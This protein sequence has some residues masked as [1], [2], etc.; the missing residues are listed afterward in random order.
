MAAAAYFF[1]KSVA[2]AQQYLFTT[3]PDDLG[4]DEA[5]VWWP[6]PI[7]A[8]GGLV[9][10]L[11]IRYLPGTGGHDPAEGF[12]ASG[13][14]PPIELPGIIIAAFAT[15]ACG[16]V[17]GPEAPLIA[18]GSGMGVLAVHLIRRNAP[19]QASVVIAAAGSFAA[20]ST[21]FGSPLTG[22]FLLME[23]SGLGGPMLGVV[24]VPGLLAAGVG[25]LI[26]IGL[27]AWTGFGNFSLAV[28]DIPTFTTPDVAQLLWAI[29]IGI[30]AAFL[31]SGIRR[32]ALWLQPVVKR[33][34][35]LLTPVAGLA[36]A[37][38]AIAFG[39][40]SDESA[41]QVLFSGQTALTG[42]IEQ[43]STWT[44]G[45]LVLLIVCKSLA[46][47]VSLS[48]F[49]GGPTFPGMFIGAVGGIAL[50]HLPGLPMIAGAAMGIGAMTV[51]MLGFPL[52]SVL[53][54]AVL[55]PTDAIALTPLVIVA[56]VVSYVTSARLEPSEP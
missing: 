17:L 13:A 23:V 15:L 41:S 24:L 25:S 40:W 10:G 12:K 35:V 44:V 56:V 36:V 22:A 46:Y 47:S 28:P 53:I 18:I 21:L 45:A 20:I 54:V 5:P 3:F 50:S 48:A 11:T 55:L 14:V 31:G 6:L 8:L 1:L 2:E 32:L 49:R 7:L 16:A 19:Q 27:N 29:G 30:A 42:L 51:A 38:L 9:V 43:A 26:F 33:R 52:T 39:E 4:F 34:M 37:G